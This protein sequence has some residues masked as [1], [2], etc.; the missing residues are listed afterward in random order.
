M[1]VYIVMSFNYDSQNFGS[2]VSA[3]KYKERAILAMKQVPAS[4][5]KDEWYEAIGAGGYHVAGDS[6][7]GG[8]YR[9]VIE[10]E[11]L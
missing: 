1:K 11:L 6:N 5:D 3:H 9:A 7:E 2:I 10:Q 4:I 8:D